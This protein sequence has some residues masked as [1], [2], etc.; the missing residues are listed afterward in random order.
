MAATDTPIRTVD[1]ALTGMTCAACA[2]RIE[3]KLNRIEGVQASV[4]LVLETAA[5]E[6]S[7]P[8]TAEDLIKAV[9][10]AGYGARQIR[11]PMPTAQPPAPSPG[12]ASDRATGAEPDP[13]GPGPQMQELPGMADMDGM[14]PAAAALEPGDPTLRLRHRVIVC[15]VLAA[16]VVLLAMI[17]PLQFTYWQWLSL[18]LAAPVVVWGAWPFHQSAWKAARHGL[19]NM[20]TLISIGVSAAFLWSLWALFLGGAGMPGMRMEFSWTGGGRAEIYLEVASAVTVFIL[21][22]NYLQARAKRR[23]GAALRALLDLGAKDVTLLPDGPD[24][25]EHRVPIGSLK[26]GDLFLVHP[27]EKIATDGEVI[28]GA[29]AVDASLLTGES[30][31]V[32]AGPGDNVTGATIAVEGRLVVRATR[33]GAD[34]A[35]A[36]IA[37][38]VSNAQ[39]GKARVQRLA[40]KVS[41]VFVPIVV[42]LALV[43]LVAWLI[44]TQDAARSFTA[45]VAVLII[46]CPCALGLATP[47]A[48]LVGTGRGAGLGIL[49]KGPEVLEAVR[50]IDTVALDKTG[51]I[52]TGRMS[53]AGQFLARGQDPAEFARRAGAVESA[54]THPVAVAVAQHAAA[55]LADAAGPA[56]NLPVPDG[57]VSVPGQGVHGVV[58][59]TEVF[60]GK[61]DWLTAQ[62]LVVHEGLEDGIG[63]GQDLGQTVVAVGWDG[64]VRGVIAVADAPKPTSAQA[65]AELKQLGMTPVLLSGDN[66]R[67]AK[68]VAA[69]VGIDR[70][71]AGVLPGQKVDVIKQ[72]QAEGAKVAMVGDGINDAPALAQANLGMAMGTGADAAIEASDLTLVRGDLRTVPDAIRLSQATLRI[73]KSNLFWAFAYNTAALPL[74]AFGLL[75]PMIAGLAMALSS[76]FVVS[77]SL[78]LRRFKAWSN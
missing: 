69:A 46:A 44:V 14:E 1:L 74:A 60:A 43:T 31:P 13:G 56:H 26:V 76:I 27:G 18:T 78:R 55:A 64:R 66:A 59:G 10:A 41:A 72:L 57:F 4:N 2:A 32:E 42:G 16:P 54:S 70:V 40:D 61:P 22:G 48:L 15:A 17:P 45:A 58:C 39:S 50:Q 67:A 24:G 29:S 11:R 68:A 35:L 36:Q 6:V 21:T 75:N 23:S 65:V 28:R 51:T 73:I 71:I 30:V 77:N 53:V 8:A 20:N 49:I 37:R 19:A 38:L 62:G 5:V 52:T 63:Q 34:T 33:V 7:G 9:E 25:P 3:K 47:T 12:V